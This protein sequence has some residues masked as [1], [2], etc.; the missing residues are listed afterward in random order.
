M[1]TVNPLQISQRTNL[2]KGGYGRVNGNP[3]YACGGGNC[4]ARGT[5]CNLVEVVD[6]TCSYINRAEDFI[7][8]PMSGSLSHN[9]TWR[10][11][12]LGMNSDSAQGTAIATDNWSA[13]VQSDNSI[14]ITLNTTVSV[15]SRQDIRGNAYGNRTVA[16]LNGNNR[17]VLWQGSNVNVA[18]FTGDLYRGSLSSSSSIRILPQQTSA[19]IYPIIIRNWV[20]GAAGVNWG[21]EPFVDEM[22]IGAVFKNNLPNSFEPPELIEIV[23]TPDICNSVVDAEFTF[24]APILNGGHLVLQWHYE[25]EDWSDR[26]TVTAPSDRDNDVTIIAHNLVPSSCDNTTVYWR[27]RFVPD[28][29]Y[30]NA[31]EWTYGEF[32]TLFIPPVWMNVPDISEDECATVSNGEELAQYKSVVYFRGEKPACKGDK[33]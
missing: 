23:Q 33:C 5:L 30:L 20:T 6:G 12:D 14:I 29:D 3:A 25:G 16:V 1:A 22:A 11:S 31:S 19:D 28:V 17:N 18:Y 2:I 15:V 7:D 27:A 24:G 21:V 13:T 26:Y 9:Y 10:D 32:D 4:Y 8:V